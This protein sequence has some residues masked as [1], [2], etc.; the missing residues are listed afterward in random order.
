[1]M[2]SAGRLVAYERALALDPD[3]SD[4]GQPIT[5]RVE[6]GELGK[7]IRTRKPW[8]ERHPEN[9]TA[10]FAFELCPPVRRRLPEAS[11]ECD[12]AVSLFLIPEIINS[13]CSVVF[14]PMGNTEWDGVSGWT[15]ARNGYRRTCPSIFARAGKPEEARETRR[16]IPG[17]KRS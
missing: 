11:K 12:P 14:D 15:R 7:F 8:V 16:K 17:G 9:A 4:A 2:F 1:V 13:V 5:N 10:H 3:F 6:R